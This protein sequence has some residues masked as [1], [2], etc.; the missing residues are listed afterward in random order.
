ML[1]YWGVERVAGHHLQWYQLI[2]Y[3][4]GNPMHLEIII[5]KNMPDLL[6]VKRIIRFY[7]YQ[8]KI[9]GVSG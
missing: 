1:P 7:T 5:L 6:A 2:Y 3:L 9:M 8:R 4:I